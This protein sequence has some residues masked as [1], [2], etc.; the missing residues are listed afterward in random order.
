MAVYRA[1]Y[2]IV[3]VIMGYKTCRLANSYTRFDEKSAS[4]FRREEK[5][6]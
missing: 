2:Y 5:W 4:I 1:Y 6:R 3:Y